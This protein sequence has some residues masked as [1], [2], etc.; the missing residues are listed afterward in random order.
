VAG[1]QLSD[2]IASPA[3]INGLGSSNV[4]NRRSGAI[5]RLSAKRCSS[6]KPQIL[7]AILNRIFAVACGRRAGPATQTQSIPNHKQTKQE[8]E[9][10]KR[11]QTHSRRRFEARS[12]RANVRC[13]AGSPKRR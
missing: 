1:T 10:D 2:G 8:H 12:R 6:R 4:M 7:L 9:N 5:A 11:N 3:G 13:F